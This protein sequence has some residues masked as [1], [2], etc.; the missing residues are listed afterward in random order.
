M[1][2]L[3]Y[4]HTHIPWAIRA[5]RYYYIFLGG[6]Q[7]DPDKNERVKRRVYEGSKSQ[8]EVFSFYSQ[9]DCYFTYFVTI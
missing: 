9:A 5:S 2:P 1:Y 4:T 6:V 8:S 7:F 3:V